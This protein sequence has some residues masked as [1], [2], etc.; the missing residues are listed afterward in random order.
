MTSLTRS[1]KTILVT[2]ATGQQ[3]GAVIDALMDLDKSGDK[4]SILAVTRKADSPAALDLVKRYPRVKLVEGNLDN[5]PALF[6]SAKII[7]GEQQLPIWGVFSVQVSMGPGVTFD[8]EVKQGKAL[9]DGAIANGVQHFVYSSVERGG[10]ARSW[11][12]PTPIPHFQTK[13]M[14]EDYLNA[15]CGKQPGSRMGWTIL[16]PVAFMDNLK[17]GMPTSLFLT[18]LKNHLGENGKSLQWIAVHDI[19]VFAAKV[20]DDPEDWNHTAVGLAGDELTVDQ[21]S[22]AFSKATGYP[23]PLTY[24]LAG[25]LLTFLSKELGLMIGWF[26][27]EG[28]KADIEARRKE[29][30]GMLT[31]EEWLLKKSQFSTGVGSAQIG[32]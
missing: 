22:R 26:A 15:T 13:K 2:G 14:I 1:K 4:F 31:M 3:G 19:G 5:V 27:S 23:V 7:A 6:E 30:P 20:F 12:N 29:L 10:D 32:A 24:S 17:P 11:D 21:L 8:G 16:R 9:I 18:A 28:Y 25:S